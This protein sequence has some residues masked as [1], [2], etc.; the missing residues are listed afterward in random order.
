MKYEKDK[1]YTRIENNEWID[2]EEY[3]RRIVRDEL[4]K[5]NKN[6]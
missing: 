2:L 3:I 5:E 1:V 6:D 4:K